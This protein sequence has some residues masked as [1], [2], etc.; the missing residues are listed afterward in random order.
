MQPHLLYGK[1]FW[2]MALTIYPDTRC[3][4]HD[5]RPKRWE[6][7]S[8][9]SD[10]HMYDMLRCVPNLL[11][12]ARYATI[13]IVAATNRNPLPCVL[14]CQGWLQIATLIT[15]FEENLCWTSS[16]RQAVTLIR[17]A[18]VEVAGVYDSNHRNIS[19]TIALLTVSLIK[20]KLYLRN[21]LR[22]KT[23]KSWLVKLSV[24]NRR[25][26]PILE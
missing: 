13:Y 26:C 3:G 8:Q 18:I 14:L 1:R 15:T 24:E 12:P 4:R 10:L 20:E 22:R 17:V 5:I 11:R 9:K 16:V 21:Q 7:M 2:F 6:N 23:L 25:M 19:S